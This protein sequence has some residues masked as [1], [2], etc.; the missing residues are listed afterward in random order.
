MRRS[1]FASVSRQGLEALEGV[2]EERLRLDVGP[3]ALR[4]LG[5]E[6]GVVDGLLVLAAAAEVVGEQLHHLV[7][8]LRVQLLDPARGGGVVLA[9]PTIEESPVHDV[10]RQRVLEA[11]HQLGIL[12]SGEDEIEA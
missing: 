10:L 1:R 11:V 6:N 5:G 2:L 3:A 8:A 12:S 7:E 4:L 9:P